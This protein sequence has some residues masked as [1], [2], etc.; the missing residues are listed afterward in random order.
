MGEEVKTVIDISNFYY[1]IGSVIVVNFGT[2]AGV[3][4]TAFKTSIRVTRYFAKLEHQVEEN[5]KDINAAHSTLRKHSDKIA[6]LKVSN[7]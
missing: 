2:L 6:E 5:T 1:L 4:F 7:R 3:V